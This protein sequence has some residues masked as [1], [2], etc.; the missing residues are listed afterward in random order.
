ML[1]TPFLGFAAPTLHTSSR[2]KDI[3]DFEGVRYNILVGHE[4]VVGLT[5]SG[6][7]PTNPAFTKQSLVTVLERLGVDTRDVSLKTKNVAAIMVA[8]R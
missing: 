3:I 8:R 4:L 1:A 7:D 2:I 5:G 6:D